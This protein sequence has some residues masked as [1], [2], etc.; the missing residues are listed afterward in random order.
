MDTGEVWQVVDVLMNVDEAVLHLHHFVVSLLC[1]LSN[2]EEEEASCLVGVVEVDVQNMMARMVKVQDMSS[3]APFFSCTFY[4]PIFNEVFGFRKGDLQ[5]SFWHRN[6][7]LF[8][9]QN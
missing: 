4:R 8:D 2:I 1:T 6:I 5:L 3:L 7:I 9:I